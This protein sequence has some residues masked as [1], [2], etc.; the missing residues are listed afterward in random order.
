M[1]SCSFFFQAEKSNPVNNCILKEERE[2]SKMA[3]SLPKLDNT[4]LLKCDL[5][6]YA[7]DWVTHLRQSGQSL[8]SY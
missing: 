6:K 4:K 3:K 1:Q 8:E 2:V 5:D 7:G